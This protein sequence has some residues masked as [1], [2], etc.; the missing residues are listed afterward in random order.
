M[1]FSGIN[2][3]IYQLKST[4][5]H[6]IHSPF[7]FD[8]VKIIYDNTNYYC[9]D[10]IELLRNKLKNSNKQISY[11][12]LGAKGNAN[13]KNVFI[14]NIAKRSIK[15]AKYG[16]LLFRLANHFQPKS[17]LELGTSLGISTSYLASVNSTN[18]IITVEGAPEVAAIAKDNFEYLQLNNI[19]QFVGNFDLVLPEL[20]QNIDK[21]DLIFFD[22]NHRKDPTMNYFKQCLTKTH[23]GSV[24]IFDDIYWSSEMKEAWTEIKNH[25]QV[26]VTVDLFQFGIVFFRSGQAKEH[27]VI[28]F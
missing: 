10:S 21:L 22:G 25:P 20:L 17:V 15:P 12:D 7:I 5:E 18:T 24:F 8:L 3:L 23:E 19:K 2:Y 9:Y 1:L 14:K 16:Q 4:N 13:N 28:Q 27:F 11:N 26:K 6:G